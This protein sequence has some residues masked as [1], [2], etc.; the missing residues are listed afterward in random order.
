MNKIKTR[1]EI[2][3]QFKWSITD[4]YENDEAW[5]AAY[6]KCSAELAGFSAFSPLTLENLD[7]CLKFRDELAKNIERVYVYAN[8]KSDEDNTNT[9]YQG[10]A[11]RA[12]ALI[13]QYS[14]SSAFIEPD[15][16]ALD[17]TEL[18]KDGRILRNLQCPEHHIRY[19]ER[20]GYNF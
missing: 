3:P 14:S 11:D 20:S 19:A 8:L 12:D 16:L 15:I 9:K 13:A 1:S 10:L 6:A 4:L 17:E 7:A 5:E 2:D 18:L